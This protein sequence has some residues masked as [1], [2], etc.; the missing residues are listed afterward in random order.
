MKKSY[1]ARY[2]SSNEKQ[3]RK[4]TPALVSMLNC[5]RYLS[6]QGFGEKTDDINYDESVNCI[7]GTIYLPDGSEVSHRSFC[8]AKDLDSRDALLERIISKDARFKRRGL[9]SGYDRSGIVRTSHNGN[10]YYFDLSVRDT[11]KESLFFPLSIFLYNANQFAFQFDMIL[12]KKVITDADLEEFAKYQQGLDDA[13]RQ[14]TLLT[15]SPQV[16]QRKPTKTQEVEIPQ[17]ETHFINP[18]EVQIP[19]LGGKKNE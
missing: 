6:S 14:L 18:W 9:D 11:T 13:M 10:G 5:R 12:N 15:Y 1:S 8:K 16:P 2:P 4:I 19:K 7:G 3:H 17:A